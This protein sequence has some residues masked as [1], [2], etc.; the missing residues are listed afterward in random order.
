M[1]GCDGLFG[2]LG[3][4]GVRFGLGRLGWR[5]GLGVVRRLG[6]LRRLGVRPG[7]EGEGLFGSL[8]LTGAGAFGSKRVIGIIY[9][10]IQQRCAPQCVYMHSEDKRFES[11]GQFCDE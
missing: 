8:G 4:L 9:G 5:R 11:F 7:R 2:R 6:F 10:L 1:V 3:L